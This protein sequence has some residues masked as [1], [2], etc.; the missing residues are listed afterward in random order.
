MSS[1]SS[2]LMVAVL[3]GWAVW[4]A[5]AWRK[6]WVASPVRSPAILFVAIGVMGARLLAVVGEWERYRG[7]LLSS[8]GPL[9]IQGAMIGFLAAAAVYAR[10][11]KAPVVEV[12]DLSVFA[13]A[14]MIVPIR[15]GCFSAGCCFG[16]PTSLP[17]AIAGTNGR[18]VHPTQIYEVVL[19]VVLVICL[20]RMRNRG[21]EAGRMLWTFLL[22]Y[23]GGRAAIEVFRDDTVPVVWGVTY[24]Q[25]VG[26]A[27]AVTGAIGGR[28]WRNR[29]HNQRLAPPTLLAGDASV[30]VDYRGEESR[31]GGRIAAR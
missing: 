25:M 21:A 29:T 16:T 27:M 9:A 23:G 14:T 28:R 7:Q 1:Y 8:S 26:I 6:G 11:R 19:G 18:H 24:P 15:I 3:M 5:E 2:C 10:L 4:T 17:W 13:L 22:A 31:I 20:R 30:A 12:L